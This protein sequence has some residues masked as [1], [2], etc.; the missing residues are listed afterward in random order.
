[1]KFLSFENEIDVEA[2]VCAG[3]NLPSVSTELVELFNALIF[4]SVF[5]DKELIFAGDVVL[6]YAIVFSAVAHYSTPP[7]SRQGQSGS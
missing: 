1:M 3:C 5:E 7:F 6:V 4:I 2:I